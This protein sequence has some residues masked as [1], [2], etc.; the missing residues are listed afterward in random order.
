[1]DNRRIIS[2]NK[3]MDKIDK[4]AGEIND[5]IKDIQQDK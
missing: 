2:N 1:M 5:I 4:I 3:H